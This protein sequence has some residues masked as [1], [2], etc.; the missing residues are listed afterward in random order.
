MTDVRGE[1]DAVGMA[2]PARAD[3]QRVAQWMK[4]WQMAFSLLG[5]GGS[6]K[7]SS[8]T[9]GPNG[10]RF[11]ILSEVRAY[12]EG[13][14]DGQS[15]PRRDQID[16]RGIAGAL[17]QVFLIE[18]I[19]PGLARFRLAG[20]GVSDVLGMD[21]RGM[22]LSAV[23]DPAARDRLSPVLETVF[24]DSLALDLWLEAERGLGRPALEA[25]MMLLPL[26]SSRGLTDLALGCLA[27]E[28]EVGRVP[29]RFAI[30]AL[31]SET[32]NATPAPVPKPEARQPVT[33]F[34]EHRPTFA[35]PRPPRGKPQ[36]RLVKFDD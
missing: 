1:R 35:P 23:F 33:G 22:P 9:G 17:E 7:G 31:L 36:L 24:R 14:R 25:R 12:W 26:V 28:G 15:L 3:N 32:L 34:A 11:A 30:S 18:R 2:K 19:A 6:T 5:R 27:M 10:P 13:L 29:R 4:G 16:P 20:M 21:V 8:T